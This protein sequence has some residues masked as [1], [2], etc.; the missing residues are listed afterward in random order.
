MFA[1]KTPVSGKVEFAHALKKAVRGASEHQRRALSALELN[2]SKAFA[3]NTSDLLIVVDALEARSRLK[4]DLLGRG[5]TPAYVRNQLSTLNQVL[6]NA[7][8]VSG[9]AMKTSP[10]FKRF[11]TLLNEG[12]PPGEKRAVEFFLWFANETKITPDTFDP[13][14][15]F[16][17]FGA[18]LEARTGLSKFGNLRK[19]KRDVRRLLSQAGYLFP[20]VVTAPPLPKAM[21]I[22]IEKLGFHATNSAPTQTTPK[23]KRKLFAELEGNTSPIRDI[24]WRATAK[25]LRRYLAFFQTRNRET[26][27][28]MT[29]ADW[30]TI[31][32][33]KEFFIDA[34]EREAFSAKTGETWISRLNRVYKYAVEQKL[35]GFEE[36]GREDQKRFSD[37]I[38]SLTPHLRKNFRASTTR[39]RIERNGGIPPWAELHKKFQ[40]QSKIE[41]K[42]LKKKKVL[43]E[44]LSKEDRSEEAKKID[45]QIAIRTEE[46]LMVAFHLYLACRKRDITHTISITHF[47]KLS[48][49]FFHL[50][51]APSKTSGRPKPPYVDV[52][53]PPWLT[54]IVE[55]YLER[56][57]SLIYPGAQLLFPAD[58]RNKKSQHKIAHS[59]EA[60]EGNYDE[61]LQRVTLK[62]FGGRVGV[63]LFRKSLTTFFAMHGIL[64]SYLFLGHALSAR[65]VG[66]T[67]I[68]T[69]YYLHWSDKERLEHGKR[70]WEQVLRLLL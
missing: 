12:S 54:P 52:C 70:H 29:L 41:F 67:A 9:P 6:R 23:G 20:A 19:F 38:W 10:W 69:E 26:F 34:H 33:V 61:W 59:G 57:H 11:G 7:K 42:L 47:K 51:Y 55:D 40:E 64:H 3:I 44:K 49:E 50:R 68:E 43:S 24:T 2:L 18:F 8:P 21:E 62:Y 32:R 27:E 58:I 28:K 45:L 17:E 65:N 30:L 46:Y 14:K 1:N 31:D 39:D 66:L 37:E 5:R 15:H 22:A 35:L 25:D 60:K 56:Y 13:M 53:L 63:N 4:A 36:R 48:N 16:P